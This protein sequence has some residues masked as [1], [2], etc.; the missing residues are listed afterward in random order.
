MRPGILLSL[1]LWAVLLPASAMAAIASKTDTIP[2]EKTWNPHPEADDILL[3]MP[4]GLKLALRVVAVPAGN[5]LQ[6]RRFFMGIGAAEN[7]KR[8][9]YER[10]FPAHIAAPFTAA[11][12]PP[13]WREALPAQEGY[14]WYF[15]GKYEISEQQWNAVMENQCPAAPVT[16]DSLPKRGISWHDAQRFIQTYNAWLLREAPDALPHFANNARSVGFLR[17]PT[18]EEWEFAARGGNRVREEDLMQEDIFPL[19]EEPLSAYG[20]FSAAT[21]VHEPA[22][23]GSYKANP[24][25]IYDTAGNVKELV[26][27]FFR[28]SVA[29]MNA[30]G[31]VSRR[32]HGAAGGILCK[33]GS[34]RSDAQG[35]LPGWRDEVPQYTSEGENRPEDLGLRVVLAG[36]NV[37][38]GQRL[39]A[40]VQASNQ[41]PEAPRPL[42]ASPAPAPQKDS[43]TAQDQ[44]VKLT[45]DASPLGALES[46][47]DAAA[48]QEMRGN[49]AQL[50][51]ILENEQAAR[52]RQNLETQEN[53]LRA[54]L[55]QAETLRSFAYRYHTAHLGLQNYLKQ[56]KSKG[57]DAASRNAR[58]I[59]RENYELIL[60]AANFYKTCLARL[61]A[62]PEKETARLLNQLRQE[63]HG[64][65]MLSQHMQQN[66][67]ALEKH[68]NTLRTKGMD[69]LSQKSVCRDIIPELHFKVL[70]F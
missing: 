10:R 15:I 49:L 61:T 26:D 60:S 5:L 45:P 66:I 21:P 31:S 1:L 36:L 38:S 50:R 23:I 53:S 47:T 48:S 69:A 57:E 34:F 20:L 68:L 12:L 32:L 43:D 46:I 42:P 2:P 16:K 13:A 29:D 3:P 6:D 33:G 67:N 4:C 9:I 63:Y 52:E 64:S 7:E 8:Q 44:A 40:L 62:L 41:T 39:R 24:L 11:D 14:T 54:L 37:P 55:Y 35:V 18:E 27:G 56:K 19:G 65:D 22:P 59:L 25:G 70:P 58:T 17:L 51:V 30:D 28:M